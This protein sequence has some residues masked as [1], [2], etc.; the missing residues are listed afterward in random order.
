M[1]ALRE[2][3]EKPWGNWFWEYY[4]YTGSLCKLWENEKINNIIKKQKLTTVFKAINL[5]FVW[6]K[7]IVLYIL[8][9]LILTYIMSVLNL[10]KIIIYPVK[11]ITFSRTYCISDFVVQATHCVLVS[12]Y[13]P[14]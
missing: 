4:L 12:E 6:K 3:L 8:Q 5:T 13:F 2:K 1:H 11:S 9:I 14:P 10:M 7:Q